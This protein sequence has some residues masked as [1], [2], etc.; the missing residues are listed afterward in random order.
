[1]L[2]RLRVM[3]RFTSDWPPCATAA[4]GPTIAARAP[5]ASPDTVNVTR[6]PKRHRHHHTG[7]QSAASSFLAPLSHSDSDCDHPLGN[8]WQ[9]PG[10]PGKVFAANRAPRQS[11]RVR[12]GALVEPGCLACYVRSLGRNNCGNGRNTILGVSTR[13]AEGWVVSQP[14]TN[15]ALSRRGVDQRPHRSD[16]SRPGDRTTGLASDERPEAPWSIKS[17]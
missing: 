5:A 2:N 15:D 13:R 6:P 10:S 14:L 17:P 7:C 1:M 8:A 3:D 12:D 11:L 9:M 16:R 4:S